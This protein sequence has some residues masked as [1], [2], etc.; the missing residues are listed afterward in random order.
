MEHLF[1][2]VIKGVLISFGQQVGNSLFDTFKIK[3]KTTQM[4]AIIKEWF[5]KIN[6]KT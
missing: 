5:K 2:F 3:E 4:T 6:K 1:L